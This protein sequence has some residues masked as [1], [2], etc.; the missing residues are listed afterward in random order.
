MR[1]IFI[2]FYMFL[3]LVLTACTNET[4]QVVESA[5]TQEEMSKEDALKYLEDMTFRLVEATFEEDGSFEQKSVLHATT[6]KVESTTAEI[7][8]KHETSPLAEEIIEIGWSVELGVEKG[9]AGDFGLMEIHLSQVTEEVKEISAKYLDEEL[10]I[11][12]GV[13]ENNN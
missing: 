3:L 12:I 9:L 13:L 8:E 1:K 6:A 11:S 7:K 10:P 5:V 4:D 2:V